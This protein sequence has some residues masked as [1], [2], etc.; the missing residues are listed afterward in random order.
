MMKKTYNKPTLSIVLLKSSTHLLT[1]SE[2][3][4]KSYQDGGTTTVG[5]GDEEN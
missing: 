5:V 2:Y 3:Q 1:A 4:V